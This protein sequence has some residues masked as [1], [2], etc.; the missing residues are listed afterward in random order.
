MS[1]VRKFVDMVTAKYP[2]RLSANG[3]YKTDRYQ[4]SITNWKDGVAIHMRRINEK[5]CFVISGKAGFS[6]TKVGCRFEKSQMELA[7][8]K[9]IDGVAKIDKGHDI[10]LA[11]DAF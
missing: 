11:H 6:R 1:V 5:G 7:I 9:F 8:E 10:K 3:V 4:L 2:I